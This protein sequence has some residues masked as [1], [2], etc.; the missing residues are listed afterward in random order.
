MVS[1]NKTLRMQSIGMSD[2]AVGTL[3]ILGILVGFLGNFSAVCYFWRRRHKTIHDLLYLA[4][5][6]VD[7]LTVL[8]T[9]PLVVSL[10][11]Y[12]NE[13][14]FGNKVFCIA[15]ASVFLFTARM[16]MFLVMM[17]CITRTFAMKYA[18]R[19]IKR[20][21]VVG[22]ITGYAAYMMVM[23]LV[24]IPQSWHNGTY[25]IERSSCVIVIFD[26]SMGMPR[27]AKYFGTIS[28]FVE[29]ALPSV[30]TFVCFMVGVWFLKSRPV[31][32]NGNENKF[33]RVS[34]T[35]AL[36]T[37]VFLVCNIPCSFILFWNGLHYLLNKVPRSKDA[38]TELMLQF[39]PIF[40][41][42]AIN[43][44]LFLWRMRAYQNWLH[45]TLRNLSVRLNQCV[46]RQ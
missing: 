14:F 42:A 40:L 25:E 16:S 28:Y 3:L 17:I 39:F 45:Q 30:I 11:N 19:P 18:N 23:Y 44:L 33:R 21:L 15:W 36:F 10:L 5:T 37:A 43:P 46:R 6:V 31:L 22:S 4:I 27:T 34:V 1:S 41:N 13:M 2:R 9:M 35:I 7:C 20:P 38:Y 26:D 24:Y 8:S 12:R 29:V 32:A